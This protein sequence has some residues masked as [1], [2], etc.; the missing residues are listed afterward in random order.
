MK[1][2]YSRYD[3]M[4]EG[5]TADT[6]DITVGA[7]YP[8]PLSLNYLSLKLSEMPSSEVMTDDKILSFWNTAHEHYGVYGY[9]DIVLTLNGIPHINFLEPG[10]K[11]LF[12]KKDDI[13]ESFNKRE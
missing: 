11:I 9:D 10:D 5:N 12:P 13:E 7:Y 8:D 3:F 4:S 2:T 1:T 6:E